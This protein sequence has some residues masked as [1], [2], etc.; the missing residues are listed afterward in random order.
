M[1]Q[2]DTTDSSSSASTACV[3]TVLHIFS[4][5][6][7]AGAEVVIFNLLRHLNE[8]AGLRV[9]ALSLNEGVLTEKLR[10]AGVTTY[11]IPEARHSFAA[12]LFR[13]ARLFRDKRV[14][15]IHSH[16]YKENLLAWLLAGWIGASDVITTIHG[17]P[18]PANTSAREARAVRRRT[19]LDYAV[20]KRFRCAVAV[21]EEMKGVLIREHGFQSSRLRVIHNGAAI[22]PHLDAPASVNGEPFHIGTVARLVPVKGLDLFLDAAAAIRREAPLVRFSILGDG[23]LRGELVQKAVDLNLG[24]CVKFLAPRPDPTSFYRTLHL[25][26]NTSLHEGIPLSMIEAMACGVPVV[27][28]AVGGIP[29]IVTHARDGFLVKARDASLFARRCLSLMRDDRLRT[30]MGAHGSVQARSRFSVSVMAET[31]GRLYDECLAVARDTKGR[32]R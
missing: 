2:P 31:Y 1:F 8:S 3:G 23:P 4:G 22:P 14:S 24:E 19:R 7:W 32:Q 18:E 15:V 20:V 26:L 30:T 12:I 27:S 9:V 6:L 16:R 29:E 17:L 25:Y 10:A 21:S 11:V 13:A 5:D 28:S